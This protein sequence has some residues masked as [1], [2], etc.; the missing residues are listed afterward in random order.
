MMRRRPPP[1]PSFAP[2][3]KT[4]RKKIPIKVGVGNGTKIE[5]L[6]A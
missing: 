4:G 2:G 1:S 6:E 5:V 3:T